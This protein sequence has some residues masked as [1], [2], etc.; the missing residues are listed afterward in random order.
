M[1]DG[2][3][4]GQSFL[5]QRATKVAAKTDGAGKPEP[6]PD[7][8]GVLSFDYDYLPVALRG[9]VKDISE[10]MQC[11]PDFAAVGAF[12]AM[13]TIIGR[14]VG[15]KPKR[16]DDWTVIPNLWGAVVGN[17]GVMKS[18]TLSA[19]LSPVKKLQAHEY[20]IFNKAMAARVQSM[21]RS[22][23]SAA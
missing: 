4:R 7:L 22:Q 23:R 16:R 8:P 15:I 14:K 18:P 2:T 11:P 17:S 1:D 6:L 3:E 9:Y 12:V 13:A 21:R 5:D 19:A 10:R 20:G